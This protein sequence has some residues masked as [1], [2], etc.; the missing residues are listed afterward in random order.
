M[1]P[2]IWWLRPGVPER[3][4]TDHLVLIWVYSGGGRVLGESYDAWRPLR[5]MRDETGAQSQHDS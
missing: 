5:R 1:M 3:Q 2:Y 4:Q